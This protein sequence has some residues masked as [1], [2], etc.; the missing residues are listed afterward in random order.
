MATGSDRNIL[1][2]AL[3]GVAACG[4]VLG[5]VWRYQTKQWPFDE[6]KPPDSP[7]PAEPSD[8]PRP[9]DPVVAALARDNAKL[10]QLQRRLTDVRVS[11][12]IEAPWVVAARELEV[13]ALYDNQTGPIDRYYRDA[14][15]LE[16]EALLRGATPAQLRFAQVERQGDLLKQVA[17][18]ALE[19]SRELE[20]PEAQKAL[21]DQLWSSNHLTDSMRTDVRALGAVGEI[22][23]RW[24]SEASAIIDKYKEQEA[25]VLLQDS[26]RSAVKD[27]LERQGWPWD[28]SPNLVSGG[29]P[30]LSRDPRIQDA[31][32]DRRLESERLRTQVAAITLREIGDERVEIARD[33]SELLRQLSGERA[34]EFI[35]SFNGLYDLPKTAW[36]HYTDPEMSYVRE[37][38]LLYLL[39]PSQI[40]ERQ[41]ALASRLAGLPERIRARV[42]D[43]TD[44]GGDV[45]EASLQA[46]FDQVEVDSG[47]FRAALISDLNKS[48]ALA[49]V[50][51]A[52]T[53]AEIAFALGLVV[54][55][56][57][58]M[59]TKVFAVLTTLHL[60]V[61]QTWEA[62]S[63]RPRWARAAMV[64]IA[65]SEGVASAVLGASAHSGA[66]FANSES[67]SMVVLPAVSESAQGL[68]LSAELKVWNWLN[69]KTRHWSP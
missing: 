36:E 1:W 62:L 51:I 46:Q 37:R 29:S 67:D 40:P 21:S 47:G 24:G 32:R 48:L 49:A 53:S 5:G 8:S 56:D 22:A 43:E 16:L 31:D 63:A 39:A 4:L 6:E 3:L 30:N 69:N 45:G 60:V 18:I 15:F 41:E 33:W 2:T 64:R 54:A 35:K 25:K 59:V 66:E 13:D 23:S 26:Y 14:H 65:C 11:P 17:E 7:R 42:T 20:T 27:V 58:T 12:D 19:T 9:E 50:E 68:V 55:P 61:D 10:R 52:L 28:M 38:L 34:N 57:P 44:S